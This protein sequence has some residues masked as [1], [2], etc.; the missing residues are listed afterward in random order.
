[1]SAYETE[2]CRIA[3]ILAKW[4]YRKEFIDSFTDEEAEQVWSRFDD[5]GKL[6]Y[7]KGK[8]DEAR[9]MVAEMAK[10]YEFAYFSNYD[11]TEDSED[12]VLWN[13]NCIS[14]MKERGLIPDDK[15]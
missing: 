13:E 15:Q 7:I 9:A 8:Y 2:V 6:A 14:E 4:R 1:M 10:Q 5:R 3:E 12:Y 11:G